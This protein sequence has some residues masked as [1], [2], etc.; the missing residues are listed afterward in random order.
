[1]ERPKA[2]A[3]RGRTGAGLCRARADSER[4]LAEARCA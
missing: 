3:E 4:A 2:R 1:M